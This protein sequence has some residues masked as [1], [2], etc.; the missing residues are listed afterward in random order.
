MFGRDLSEQA[1]SDRSDVPVIVTKSI[2]A[3]E[4][5]GKSSLPIHSAL[6]NVAK[7]IRNGI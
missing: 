6:K 7:H 1:A 2:S 5:V 4:E 3:V